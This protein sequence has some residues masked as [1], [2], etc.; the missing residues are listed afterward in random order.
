MI[1]ALFAG[2]GGAIAASS[3]LG[4]NG[5]LAGFISIDSCFLSANS[6]A[7]S[8]LRDASRALLPAYV[9]PL[10]DYCVVFFSLLQLL[11]APYQSAYLWMTL[12]TCCTVAT[13]IEQSS[14]SST[15]SGSS[16]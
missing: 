15:A 14:R 3:V 13:R 10:C 16:I 2:S 7:V 9:M 1:A 8:V 6:A 11:A 4:Y 5:A 12:S